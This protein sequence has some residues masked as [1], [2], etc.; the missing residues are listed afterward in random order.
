MKS[1][2]AR[3]QKAEWYLAN[4]MSFLKP[5][6]AHKS[7][8]SSVPDDVE[9]D[10]AESTGSPIASPPTKVQKVNESGN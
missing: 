3:K 10:D 1:G 2:S 7:M 9:G 5:Y 6:L 4:Q 8:V